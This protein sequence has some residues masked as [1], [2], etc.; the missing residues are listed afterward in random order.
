MKL[1]N[2]K[3]LIKSLKYKKEVEKVDIESQ[4]EVKKTN[5]ESQNEDDDSPPLFLGVIFTILSI[6]TVI[7]MIIAIILKHIY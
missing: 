3:E 2:Y 5:I 6:I 7:S 4:K 1:I